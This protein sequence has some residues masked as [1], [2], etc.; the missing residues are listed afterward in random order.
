MDF[1]GSGNYLLVADYNHGNVLRYDAA[2]GDF[3]D[4]FVPK[5]SGG[6]NEPWF[7]VLGPHDQNLYVGSG[8]LRGVGQLKAVLRYDGATGEFVDRFVDTG[9]PSRGCA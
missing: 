5:R 7:M 4:E 1:T 9:P 3:V 8:H 2:T 6:L